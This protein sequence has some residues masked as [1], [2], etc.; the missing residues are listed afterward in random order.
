[1]FPGNL[2]RGNPFDKKDPG[3]TMNSLS[4][5]NLIFIEMFENASLLQNE[6]QND[7][8]FIFSVISIT[9]CNGT[10]MWT[11]CIF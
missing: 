3:E 6:I 10:V 5:E 11:L 7:N 2:F 9:H 4:E 8:L 1:M